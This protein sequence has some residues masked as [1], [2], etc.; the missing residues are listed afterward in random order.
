MSA[1]VFPELSLTGYTCADLFL[2]RTLLEGA[3][4]SLRRILD[5]LE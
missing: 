3:Q 1:I 2:Q 5:A 4:E